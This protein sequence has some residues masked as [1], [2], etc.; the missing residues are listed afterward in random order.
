MA[1][2]KLTDELIKQFCDLV[3]EGH[4][5]N[6]AAAKCGVHEARIRVWYKLGSQENENPIFEKFVVECDKARG[7]HAAK[8]LDAMT[9]CV[10]GEKDWKMYAW[11]LE[12][13]CPKTFHLTT[14]TELSG[15]EGGPI[16]VQSPVIMIPKEDA[17]E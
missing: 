15:P 13:L 1:E 9:Q 3:R 17:D 11:K 2:I 14:K 8:L 10:P 12:R 16:Q 5:L 7:E 6:Y 4:Y